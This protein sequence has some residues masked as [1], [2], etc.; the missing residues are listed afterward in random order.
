[1]F[2][3]R[4]DFDV[5]QPLICTRL[6]ASHTNADTYGDSTL[7]DLVRGKNAVKKCLPGPAEVPLPRSCPRPLGSTAAAL[8]GRLGTKECA[9]A[10]RNS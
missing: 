10:I 3:Q 1:M 4:G 6:L 7:G 5:Q 2:D 8:P 9:R